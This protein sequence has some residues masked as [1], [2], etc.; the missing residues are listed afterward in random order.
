[1]KIKTSVTLSKDLL[2][3]VDSLVLEEGN[4]SAFI[5]AAVRCY[6]E[7]IKRRERDKRDLEILNSSSRRLNLEARDVLSYQV[8]L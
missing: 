6:V 2:Q 8:E 1:M 5:E 3:T 7:L 4:R